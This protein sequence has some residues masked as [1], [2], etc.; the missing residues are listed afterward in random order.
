MSNT[1]TIPPVGSRV[2]FLEGTPQHITNAGTDYTVELSP[3]GDTHSTFD[4]QP[5]VWLVLTADLGKVP[6][7]RRRRTGYVRSLEVVS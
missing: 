6:S 3:R 5:Y 7:R 2:R 1:P 4:G